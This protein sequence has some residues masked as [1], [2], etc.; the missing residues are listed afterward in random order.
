MGLL[1]SYWLSGV[2]I[3]RKFS[4]LSFWSGIDPNWACSIRDLLGLGRVVD[5]RAHQT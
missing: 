4:F 3:V 2:G 5:L 1:F